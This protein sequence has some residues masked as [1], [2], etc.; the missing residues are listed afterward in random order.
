MNILS[1]INVSILP[2]DLNQFGIEDN[3]NTYSIALNNYVYRL[4]TPYVL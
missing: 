2:I 1:T 4:P 3:Y